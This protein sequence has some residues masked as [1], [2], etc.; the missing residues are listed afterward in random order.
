MMDL[1][2]PLCYNRFALRSDCEREGK[3]IRR[4]LLLNME[5]CDHL[6]S[7]S[8]TPPN[9]L[10]SQ[11]TNELVVKMQCVAKTARDQFFTTVNKREE[12]WSAKCSPCGEVVTDTI[13]VTSNL[14]RHVK[15]RHRVEFDQWSKQLSEGD[16]NQPKLVDYVTKKN[17]SSPCLKRSYRANH[18]RQKELQNAIVQDLIIDLGLPLSLVERPGFLQFMNT[19]DSKFS[20]ISRRTLGRTTIP[21][22][23]NK[24]NE[25][26]KQFCSSA[27]FISLTLDIWTDRR[28]RPFFSITGEN[29][30]LFV[31]LTRQFL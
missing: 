18:E 3:E 14:N 9:S 26:L 28:M 1:G 23:Y 4:D 13:G 6:D 24:M 30:C 22:L 7:I 27:E 10:E 15:T 8:S 25:S 11:G 12:N 31:K 2:R 21:N 17:Q 16:A 19:V 5:N 20:V 29:I